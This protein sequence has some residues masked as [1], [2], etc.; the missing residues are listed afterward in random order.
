MSERFEDR[1]RHALR[2]EAERVDPAVDDPVAEVRRRARRQ[3]RNRWTAAGVCLAAVL[4]VAGGALTPALRDDAAVE[5]DP[6]PADQPAGEDPGED[7]PAGED[8]GEADDAG[9]GGPET[10][11]SETG[12]ADGAG[13]ALAQECVNRE[14][15]YRI[16]YPRGWHVNDPEGPDSPCSWFHPEPFTLPEGQEVTDKAVRV[17]VDPVAF[18]RA[19]E[20]GGPGTKEVLLEERL[21]VAG[22]EAVAYEIVASREGLSP[23]GTR[24]YTHVVDLGEGRSLIVT[25]DD[26][27]PEVAYEEAKAVQD[28]MVAS[29]RLD[30]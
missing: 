30:G 3:T 5:L 1:L 20:P 12:G 19:G 28:R 17:G 13:P 27:V 24:H 21:R 2:H 25:T 4:A 29:L 9:Q 15:G 7:P 22:R 14:D 11:G 18:E 6:A 26:R 16:R 23:E 10:G 8:P